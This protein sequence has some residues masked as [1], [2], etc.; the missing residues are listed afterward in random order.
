VITIT[1]RNELLNTLEVIMK[2]KLI[3]LGIAMT[4][5]WLIV[6]ISYMLILGFKINLVKLNRR[7]LYLKGYAY[8]CLAIY[9]SLNNL[10]AKSFPT[11]GLNQYL[12]IIAIIESISAFA[13]WLA[14]D[15]KTK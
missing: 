8:L 10:S 14:E 7:I 15:S 5:P 3:N 2:D 6:S 12:V 9:I 11:E 4:T 13:A 1:I